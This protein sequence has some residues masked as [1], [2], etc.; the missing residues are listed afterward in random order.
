[1]PTSSTLAA[2]FN[3]IIAAAAADEVPPAWLQQLAPHGRIVAPVGAGSQ[4][5]VVIERDAHGAFHRRD[6]EEV[7]FVPL[8][9]G[10]E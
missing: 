2:P 4:R 1:M 10:I 9:Q 8:K 5:L 6:G 7:R 3:A